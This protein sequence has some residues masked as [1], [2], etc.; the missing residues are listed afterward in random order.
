MPPWTNIW[1]MASIAL[2]MSLHF[3]ILYVDI[4]S[5]IFQIT[6]LN[7]V[8]WFAV[9]K[10]SFPVI[11]LDETLKLVARKWI[12]GKSVFDGMD[13]LYL[14]ATWVVYVVVIFFLLPF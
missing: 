7:F 14:G 6:P 8:E 2:S 3:V 4:L 5:T 13:W 1:L 10:I 12:D 11:I 9:L